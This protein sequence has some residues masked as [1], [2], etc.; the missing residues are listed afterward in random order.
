MLRT[1]SLGF[2]TLLIGTGSNLAALVA[3]GGHFPEFAP[4]T[5]P[6]YIDA[7]RANL[8]WLGDW[9]PIGRFW[10]SPGDFF[11]YGGLALVAV[12]WVMLIRYGL[13]TGRWSHYIR[14]LPDK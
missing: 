3:N 5:Y 7:H 10:F 9:L 8:A 1:L 14:D 4:G 13:R 6:G 2:I 11:I 12:A